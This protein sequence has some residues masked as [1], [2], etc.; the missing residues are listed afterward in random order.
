[1]IRPDEQLKTSAAATYR[2][3]EW[4]ASD[5]PP[6]AY[7]VPQTKHIGRFIFE[8][9]EA[10]PGTRDVIDYY[11]DTARA[12]LLQVTHYY[13][14]TPEAARQLL[15]TLLSQLTVV[16]L[17]ACASSALQ[18]GDLRFCDD[19]ARPTMLLFTR[20]N[21]LMRVRLISADAVA[22]ADDPVVELSLALDQALLAH[23]RQALH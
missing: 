17:P 8:Q 14:T 12:H 4:P 20:S 3:E 23:R 21:S 16:S 22:A 11:S 2:F 19:D 5:D 6:H 7:F 15:L 1:M 13:R 9:R 10:L 18:V